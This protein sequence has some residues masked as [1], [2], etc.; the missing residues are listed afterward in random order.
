MPQQVTY[1]YLEKLR[2]TA[3]DLDPKAMQAAHNRLEQARK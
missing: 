2:P 1:A 3:Y